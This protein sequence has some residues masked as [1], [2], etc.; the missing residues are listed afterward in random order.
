LAVLVAWSGCGKGPDE[1]E[2]R[3]QG[4]TYNEL[5]QEYAAAQRR[6]SQAYAEARSEQERDNLRATSPDPKKYAARFLELARQ[7]PQDPSALDALIWVAKNATTYSEGELAL[8]L[9]ARDYIQSDQLGRVCR[10]AAHAPSA[11]TE[12]FL[13]KVLT[14]SPHHTVQGLACLNLGRVLKESAPAEA[15]QYF[16]QVITQFTDVKQ[17]DTL[18]AD[19]ARGELFEMK[20]L[21]IGQVAPD[22][23][24]EDVDGNK[25]KLSEYRGKVVV[26]DFWGDWCPTCQDLYPHARSL[27]QRLQGKPFA[28]LGINT[29]PK[30][31]LRD[32]LKRENL[33]WRSWW[34]GGDT[35][36]PIATKWNV[37]S[38]PTIYVLDHKGVI[39]FKGVKK[40]RLDEAVDS[41]LAE[42]RPEA[43]G[44]PSQ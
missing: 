18:A 35:R 29:D 22:I 38:W 4:K 27:V 37:H 36:G 15:E 20:F 28:L 32:A 1:G 31:K 44:Q 21:A 41:L 3:P 9:L 12:R 39:R 7:N 13:G 16:N 19:R 30:D 42:M 40:K 5:A 34:D 14:N 43:A 24:G 17:D 6:F 11:A 25:F 2:P 23:E 10:Y 8:T 33:T 26:L